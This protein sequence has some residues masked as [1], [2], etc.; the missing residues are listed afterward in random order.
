MKI[1]G[2]VSKNNPKDQYLVSF[3][4]HS[5]P[6][7]CQGG[8]ENQQKWQQ[9]ENMQTQIQTK[10]KIV[11]FFECVAM[12]LKTGGL[13]GC[14]FTVVLLKKKH[15]GKYEIIYKRNKRGAM[16][17]ELASWSKL[18]V[19]S[20]GGQSHA[21]SVCVHLLNRWLGRVA[22]FQLRRNRRKWKSASDWSCGYHDMNNIQKK[23]GN[24]RNPINLTLLNLVFFFFYIRLAHM[25]QS[26]WTHF[27]LD[28]SRIHFNS[29]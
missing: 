7:G 28:I 8:S 5:A 20:W 14:T 10:W 25:Q 27:P 12:L 19:V 3:S 18:E 17:L 2:V 11:S 29:D 9:I 6:A 26:A 22:M 15:V 24:E 16:R 23:Y 13:N 1:R 21:F 4:Y